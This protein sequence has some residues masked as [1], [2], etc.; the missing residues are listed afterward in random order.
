MP[1]LKELIAN[2]PDKWRRLNLRG[3]EGQCLINAGQKDTDNIVGS[4][5]EIQV[6][7][8]VNLFQAKLNELLVSCDGFAEFSLAK[9]LNALLKLFCRHVLKNGL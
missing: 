1:I 7:F 4:I 6:I 8:Q 2:V 3:E 9:D 5:I